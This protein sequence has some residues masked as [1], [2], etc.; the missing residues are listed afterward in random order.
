MLTLCEY[1]S[2]LDALNHAALKSALVSF[3]QSPPDDYAL[4]AKEGVNNKKKRTL[5]VTYVRTIL[6]NAGGT[7]V[8]QRPGAQADAVPRS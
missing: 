2:Q 4:A 3:A 6:N 8:R 7:P 5:R 1:Y